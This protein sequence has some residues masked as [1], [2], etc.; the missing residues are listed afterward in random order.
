MSRLQARSSGKG[1]LKTTTKTKSKVKPKINKTKTKE[2]QLDSI[3]SFFSKIDRNSLYYSG[4][5][6]TDNMTFAFFYADSKIIVDR[7]DTKGLNKFKFN[8][9]DLDMIVDKE[10]KLEPKKEGKDFIFDIGSVNCNLFNAMIQLYPDCVFHQIKEFNGS[11]VNSL[12]IVLQEEYGKPIG[13][14]KTH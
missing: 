2:K 1:R 8:E 9:A 6:L 14:F 10:T 11:K 3:E 13:L 12:I 7:I 4:F 5:C